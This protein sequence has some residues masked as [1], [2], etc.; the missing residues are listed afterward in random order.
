MCTI[1]LVHSPKAHTIW[2]SW[3]C[4][5]ILLNKCNNVMS[6]IP[7]S[8]MFALITSWVFPF[9]HICPWNFN[10]SMFYIYNCN[11][12]N[13]YYWVVD[14]FFDKAYVPSRLGS[15]RV[16]TNPRV[17]QKM[18]GWETCI[19]IL[20]QSQSQY[21]HL[22]YHHHVVSTKARNT[23]IYNFLFRS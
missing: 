7:P 12:D 14:L 11:N 10:S 13:K 3:K 4:H 1:I 15:L 17:L 20:E 21:Y 16:D 18:G 22:H 9:C 6:H 8:L 5:V 23:T 19:C 2:F